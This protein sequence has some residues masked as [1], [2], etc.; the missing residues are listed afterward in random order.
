MHLHNEGES[1]SLVDKQSTTQI[2]DS[3]WGLDKT[4]HQWYSSTDIDTAVLGV[5]NMAIRLVFN[6]QM[7]WRGEARSEALT[8]KELMILLMC[9]QGYSNKRIAEL[10][11]I[12]YQTVKNNFHKL[13]CK[14]GAKTNAH[15]LFLAMEAGFISIEWIPDHMD[16]SVPLSEEGREEIRL[17]IM[18]E[19][20]KVSQMNRDEAERYMGEQNMKALGVRRR[21]KTRSGDDEKPG[22]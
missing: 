12:A 3:Q 7:G 13:M 14:L 4:E 22:E 8:Y 19:I 11:G 2:P 20:E 17:G 1:D 10:L 15:A 21:K 5:D 16:E 18:E 9:A 6:P